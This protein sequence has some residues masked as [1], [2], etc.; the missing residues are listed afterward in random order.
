MKG[1]RLVVVGIGPDAQNPKHR[2][3]LEF[4]GGKHVFYVKDYAS[5]EDATTDI[6]NLI[7]RKYNMIVMMELQNGLLQR[8]QQRRWQRL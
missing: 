3:V 8:E 4:I 5:L 6:T 7:C 2:R 1:V